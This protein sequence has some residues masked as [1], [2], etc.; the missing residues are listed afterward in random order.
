M[1]ALI[2]TN[3]TNRYGQ[4]VAQVEPN[5]KIF[6]VAEGLFWIDCA[7]DVVADYYYY[8]AQDKQIKKIPEVEQ[9]L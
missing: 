5:D 3:E 2:S 4:R 8:D 7:N 9:T 1:K 6:P